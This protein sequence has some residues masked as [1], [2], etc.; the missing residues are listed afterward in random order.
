MLPFFRKKNEKP[1]S[2]AEVLAEAFQEV[3][4]GQKKRSRRKRRSLLWRKYADRRILIVLAVIA[5]VLIA[6]GVRR[7]N[8]EFYAT[9]SELSGTGTV[10][11]GLG[12]DQQP[13]ALNQRISDGGWVRTG[14]NGW[15]S[16]RFPDGSVVTLGPSSELVV[17]LLE[18]NRGGMWRGRAFTLNAGHLWARVSPKFGQESTQKVH[19]PTS[20]AAVRGTRF[21]MFYDPNR[22]E[23]SVSCND[24]IVRVDGFQGDGAMV[25]GGRATAVGY[26]APPAG[27][28]TMDNQT[29]QS[30]ATPSLN[31]EIEPDSWLKRTTMKITSILD[32]PL[33][34]LGIGKSSWAIGAADFARRNAAMEAMRRIHTAIEGYP[35]YPPFVD[36]FTLAELDFRPEDARQILRNFDGHS[37]VKYERSGQGFVMYARARDNARTPFRLS[38]Y[39]VELI[40]EDEMPG[41]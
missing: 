20:V 22:S 8:M 35:T 25:A 2:D 38:A 41:F 24:G 6:D 40:T 17:E 1:K 34:I 26:G 9:V 31:E 5:V 21:Y 18:Y 14:P 16:L 23:T 4:S 3:E 12:Q 37:L 32:L 29:R 27:L 36:P 10:L 33:S 19:T 30:F 13:L 11:P 28:E 39:G 7:E 15:T